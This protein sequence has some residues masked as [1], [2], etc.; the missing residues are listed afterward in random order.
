M[1]PGTSPGKARSL[2][3]RA[4]LQPRLEYLC[5]GFHLEEQAAQL[6]T[7]LSSDMVFLAEVAADFCE[8]ATDLPKA[9]FGPCAK[10]PSEFVFGHVAENR[11]RLQAKTDGVGAQLLSLL[12]KGQ[13]VLN[14]LPPR[15]RLS[16][17][18]AQAISPGNG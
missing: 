6:G 16:N 11:R 9:Q 1:P 12:P 14:L 10:L 15:H 7:S 8:S 17:K 4:I 3:I 13:V 2:L 18:M 5:F